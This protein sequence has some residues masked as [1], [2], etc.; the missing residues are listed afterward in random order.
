MHRMRLPYLVALAAGVS[1]CAG[2]GFMDEARHE[3][4]V[5][6]ALTGQSL[7]ADLHTHTKFSDGA[8]EMPDLVKLAVNGGCQVLAVTD[9]SDPHTKTATSRY[10]AATREARAAY[11]RLVLFAGLEWN[12]PPHK[13][14]EHV[15]VLVDPGLEAKV[16]PDFK[17]Q[18]DSRDA[19]A[20]DALRWLQGKLKNPAQAALIY[21]H[22]TRQPSRAAAAAGKDL[23]GWRGMGPLMVAFEG[24]PGHQKNTYAV[25][26]PHAHRWDTVASSVGGAWDVLLDGGANVWGA[27][28]SSDYHGEQ[29]DHPPCTFSRTFIQ[30]PERSPAG[31]LQALH[32]GTYWAVHGRILSYLLFTVSAP[33]LSAP[34]APG[35]TIAIREGKSVVARVAL[36]RDPDGEAGALSAEIIGNCRSGT[37]ALIANLDLAP[38]AQNAETSV[39]GLQPGADR[40]SCYL[41]ARIRKKGQT[42]DDWLAY[43]NPIRIKL[44]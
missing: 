36:E 18:F 44:R 12:V 38:T 5:P 6:W 28:A 30:V 20:A 7:V 41:R 4:T 32:A 19:T 43:T 24:A 9:H 2:C 13:G 14:Q 34:A 40:A 33:G 37:P 17:R 25:K 26:P 10:F 15:G 11:P 16:L 3:V 8:L 31:V 39:P 27:I 42:G 35:E 1:L 22:P 21:H 29:G 23:A